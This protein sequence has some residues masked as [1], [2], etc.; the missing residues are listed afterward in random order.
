MPG[1]GAAMSAQAEP[2]ANGGVP[3]EPHTPAGLRGLADFNVDA[4][5][6]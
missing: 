1:G 6:F 2:R 3:T 4:F 5:N